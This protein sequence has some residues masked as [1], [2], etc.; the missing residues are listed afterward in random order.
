MQG[1]TLTDMLVAETEKPTCFTNVYSKFTVKDTVDV[2]T[3]RRWLRR[4]NP[5]KA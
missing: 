2:S 5:L 1:G 3:G 4:I